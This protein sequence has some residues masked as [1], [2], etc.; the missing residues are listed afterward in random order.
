VLAAVC[1]SR[2]LATRS[3]TCARERLENLLAVTDEEL[4][5]LREQVRESLDAMWFMATEG[6]SRH[7][8]IAS[9]GA[10]RLAGRM[11]VE[12]TTARHV[13]PSG[14]RSAQVLVDSLHSLWSLCSTDMVGEGRAAFERRTRPP[15]RA[16]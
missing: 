8:R 11:L 5:A 1:H 6:R 14:S 10:A 15:H 7:Y 3:E 9:S 16:P 4:D 2:Q 13:Y 12:W